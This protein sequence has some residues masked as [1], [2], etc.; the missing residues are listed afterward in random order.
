M[1]MSCVPVAD[2]GEE[3]C[4]NCG[5]FGSD[6]V[7]LKNCTGFCLVKFCG[8]D[9]CQRAHRSAAE[10]K[11]KQL[12]S[13]GHERPKGDFCPICTLPIPLP[14][15]EHSA[16]LVCCMKMICHGCLLAM[17]K[18]GMD[19]CPF[20]RSPILEKD[21]YDLTII[22]A[23]VLKKDP[24]AMTFLGGQYFAGQFGLQKD[25]KKAVELWTEAAELGSIEALYSLGNE[26]GR[27][28]MVQQD[29]AK[30][31][32]FHTKAA[33][34]GHALARYYLGL[35]EAGKGNVDRA[36][37]H[38]LISAKMGHYDSVESIKRAFMIGKATK[39]QYA[40]A[41][42]GYQ[43]AAEEMK[44]HGRDEAKRLRDRK[45]RLKK[46]RAVEEMKSHDRDEA[47]RLRGRRMLRNY[48]ARRFNYHTDHT[49]RHTALSSR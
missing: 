46:I 21:A 34:R 1:L 7:K 17:E 6:T 28:E 48:R 11:D 42:K 37:R 4:A 27:G 30:A 23:R 44:S 43:D 2:D 3:V 12:Y 47:K 14:T 19:D 10:L 18:R 8:G 38:I 15:Y 26:Y 45:Q 49:T 24:E 33:I 40:E 29:K 35:Y 9:D 22:E 25:S 41:L 36:V 20:C 16:F 39:E 13:Q 32:E 31:A 5:K